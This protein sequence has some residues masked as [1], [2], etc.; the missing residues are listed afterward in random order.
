MFT[1]YQVFY[2]Q[3]VCKNCL[4]FRTADSIKLTCHLSAKTAFSMTSRSANFESKFYM[5]LVKRIFGIRCAKNGKK[6]SLKSVE[7]IQGK[8]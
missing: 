2:C 5:L 7:V 1:I 8:L 4:V 3:F 6:N